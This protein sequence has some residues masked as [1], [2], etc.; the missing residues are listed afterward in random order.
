MFSFQFDLSPNLLIEPLSFF[1]D[2]S[3]KPDTF[4]KEERKKEQ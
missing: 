3:D 2:S 4:S 1:P